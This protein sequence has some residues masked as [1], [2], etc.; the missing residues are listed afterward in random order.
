MKRSQ[1]V[2]SVVLAGLIGTACEVRAPETVALEPGPGASTRTIGA[3]DLEALAP[4]ERLVIDSRIQDR[5]VFH[6]D[7]EVI[8]FGRITLICPN[9]LEMPM[10]QWLT[11]QSF[12]FGIDLQRS[13]FSVE[14]PVPECLPGNE[15]NRCNCNQNCQQCPDGLWICTDPCE[16]PNPPPAPPP[17]GDDDGAPPRDPNPPVSPPGGGE[18]YPDQPDPQDP[19]G[20]D[21]AP[22]DPDGDHGGEGDGTAGQGGGGYGGGS[23]GGSSGGS[24]GGSAGGGGGGSGS[25]TGGNGGGSGGGPAGNP[26]GGL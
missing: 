10:D 25:P 24:S 19:L 8:D 16:G 5:V 26:G 13:L 11:G 23:G 6:A 9:A 15:D 21:G 20:G 2:R 22:S 14:V 17:A 4:G 7:R 3:A 12:L 18:P 1:V